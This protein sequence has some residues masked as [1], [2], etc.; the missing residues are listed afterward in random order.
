MNKISNKNILILFTVFSFF[1]IYFVIGIKILSDTRDDNSE[2]KNYLWIFNLVYLILFPFKVHLIGESNQE[3]INQDNIENIKIVNFKISNELNCINI[4]YFAFTYMTDLILFIWGI[5]EVLNYNY[6][7]NS[8]DN[9]LILGLFNTLM[10]CILLIGYTCVIYYI[11]KKN[12][13][14]NVKIKVEE[15]N[16]FKYNKRNNQNEKLSRLVKCKIT[17]I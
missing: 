8:F 16:K 3:K 1:I 12:Y 5:I 11:V 15:N 10:S 13:K 7:C 17:D 2:C 9:K 4:S 14:N 6:N